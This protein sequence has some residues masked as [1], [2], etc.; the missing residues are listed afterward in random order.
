[1]LIID[2]HHCNGCGTC[3]HACSEGA[4]SLVEGIPRINSSLCTECQACV[5][6]CPAGAIQVPRPIAQ[7]EPAAV[8]LQV[9]RTPVSTVQRGA[10]T[11]LGA[12]ILSFVSHYLLPRATQALISA[13]ERRP[14]GRAG[15]VGSKASASPTPGTPAAGGGA[16]RLG[17]HRRRHRRRE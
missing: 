7:R 9:Q 4:I 8:A 3:A 15:V 14:S 6:A 12:A 1:M 5:D 13:L 17:G 10:L 16:G 2:V 11:A